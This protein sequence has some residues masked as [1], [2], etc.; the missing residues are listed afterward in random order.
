[1]TERKINWETAE[2]EGEGRGEDSSYNSPALP[3]KW[4]KGGKQKDKGHR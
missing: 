1:M 2:G 3:L 4:M